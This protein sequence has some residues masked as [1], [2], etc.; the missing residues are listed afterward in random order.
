MPKRSRTGHRRSRGGIGLVVLAAAVFAVT[1]TVGTVHAQEAPEEEVV[2]ST[3]VEGW[4]DVSPA[5]TTPPDPGCAPAPLCPPTVPD[6]T[7]THPP[8]SLHVAAT[9]GRNRA[10]TTFDLDTSEV[11]LEAE[12]VG[13]T[14][15][16]PLAGADHGTEAPESAEMIACLL[17]EEAQFAD[18]TAADTAPSYDCSESSPVLLDGTGTNEPYFAADLEPFLAAWSAGAPMFG[19]AVVPAPTFSNPLASWHVAIPPNDGANVES[20]IHARLVVRTTSVEEELLLLDEVLESNEP[21]VPDDPVVDV[22]F[23]PVLPT[24]PCVPDF[25]PPVDEPAAAVD[26][27]PVTEIAEQPIARTLLTGRLFR[28]PITWLLPLVGLVLVHLLGQS[29]AQPIRSSSG[30]LGRALLL[31]PK[32]DS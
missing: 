12:L 11:P 20:G 21:F 17:T 22:P 16:L 29:L 28:N 19:L 5:A 8:G 4:Y 2:V 9:L 26:R 32:E 7:A 10:I 18:G 23:D 1:P 24:D 3:L 30:P 31:K 15:I 13:G 25:A 6:P 14:L 27:A